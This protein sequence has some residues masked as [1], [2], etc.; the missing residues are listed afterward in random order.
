[1]VKHLVLLLQVLLQSLPL[2]VHWVEV[3]L[4]VDQVLRVGRAGL[5][6]VDKVVR[7]SM[8]LLEIAKLDR[9][10]LAIADDRNTLALDAL[11]D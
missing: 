11:M 9:F 8:D 10:A 5:V 6:M 7:G 4:A 3:L 2:M 1:M